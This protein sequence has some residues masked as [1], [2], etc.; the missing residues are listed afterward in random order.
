MDTN[1]QFHMHSTC[2]NIRF[3]INLHQVALVNTKLS[4][5]GHIHRMKTLK[6]LATLC[7][8]CRSMYLKLRKFQPENFCKSIPVYRTGY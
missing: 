6:Y 5:L 4:Y 2:I 7:E 3:A 8:K 1:L